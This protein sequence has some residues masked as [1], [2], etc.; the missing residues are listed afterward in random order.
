MSSTDGE[1]WTLNGLALTNFAS[2]GGIKFRA[3]NAWTINWGSTVFPNGTGTSGGSNIQCIAGTYDVT[4]N[5]TT[6]AYTFT[7]AVTFPSIGIIGTVL[8]PNGFDG[9]DVD[10]T[11]FDGVNYTLANYNFQAGELKFRLDDSWAS[12]WGG[13]NF[14][15]G[16]CYFKRQ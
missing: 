1:H 11:T 2:G 13:G 6:G 4:F 3:N 9:P 16:N 15:S 14:P 10:M 7:N 12:N 8:G 5:S